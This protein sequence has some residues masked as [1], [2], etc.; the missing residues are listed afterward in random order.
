MGLGSGPSVGGQRPRN[1]NFTIEGVDNNN[2]SV[3]G[4]LAT[5]PNDAVENL[6]V[7]TNQFNPEFG[8]SSGGQFNTVIKSGT[9][10]FHG[11]LYEYGRNRNLNAVDNTFV[12]QGLTSNPR[13]DSNRFGGTIGGPIL[14]NKLFFF[15]NLEWQ[16]IGLIGAVG[17]TVEA[18]TQAGLAAIEATPGISATNLGVFEKYVPVAPASDGSTLTFSGNRNIELGAISITPPAWQ[19]YMNWVQSVD[20]NISEKDQL[21]GRF[22]Y[23][24]LDEIDTQAQLGAFFTTQPFRWDL[25]NLSEYH[26]FTPNVTNEFRIGFNRYDNTTPAGNFKFPGLDVFPNIQL[27]DLGGGLN[28]GPDPNAPQFTIQNFYQVVDNISWVKG[29]HT[30]KFGGEYREYISP[31]GFTQRARGDYEY[32]TTELF[33]KDVSPDN[34]G[35]RS[36]GS[37]TYYGNQKAVYFYLGDSWRTTSHLTLDYG[38]RYEYTTNPTGENVQA[39]NSLIDRPNLIVPQVGQPLVYRKPQAPK[40]N[41]APRVGFAYSPGTSGNTSIRG[42]FGLAYD[43][44]YD[45]IGIL[46]VPPQ[47]GATFNVDPHALTPGFFASGALPGGGTG[48]TQLSAADALSLTSS[49]IPP[50]TRWPYTLS[51]NLG[52]Q[53]SF[54]RNYTGEIRYVGTRGNNL[55]VQNIFTL[56]SPLTPQNALPLFMQAPA[57]STVDS[58]TSNLSALNSLDPFVPAY[59]NAGYTQPFITGFLPIG[60]STYHGL[61]T[62]LSRRFTNGLQF[63][64]S[65]TWSRTIDNSTA[66]FHST[67]LTPRRQQDFQNTAAE[68]GVSA[69]NRTH[70]LTIAAIY[71]LPYFKNGNWVK[72][73]LLGNWEFAPIY[74]YESPEWV[75]VQSA[76]DAN[77]N[78]D[79]AGDRAIFNAH[80]VPGTGSDVT[81]LCKS[82]L[83]SFA[84]CGENDYDPTV[85][86]TPGPGNFDSTPYLVAYQANNPNAQ[87]IRALPGMLANSSRNTLASEPTNDID[88]GIYKSLKF[89]ERFAFRFGAQIANIINHP[90][91]IPGTNPG[92]GL[93]VNDVNGFNSFGTTYKSYL[94]PGN[95]NFNNPKSVFSS[96]ARTMAIMVKVTF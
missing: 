86:K 63:N 36:S 91:Y 29:A 18:P 85:N 34:F 30:L 7:L 1:N 69:L 13:F 68:K 70:R 33:L 57:Q 49:W 58:L 54:A 25:F 51:W 66:D 50:H 77:L 27:D 88:M 24:K 22:I 40:N 42:G 75:S 71:D 55:D 9:N 39:L 47:I 60:W 45:N 76:A 61:Q 21:R 84:S 79:S 92:S 62:S 67:D 44:L 43:V 12:N 3:T 52:V 23:N 53:H 35:Q 73:N 31:Q 48:V 8:H 20:Y 93:G 59:E 83:P 37:N 95:A 82:T 2:K 81:P 16:R 87:Y 78:I 5:V 14:K 32:N 15:T 96:N 65:Y 64:V 74:T 4:F 41:W 26:T 89:G 6:S 94:T 17:G 11:S 56:Q 46:S 19:N 72:K 10:S 38:I 28:I 90:Q 80:G